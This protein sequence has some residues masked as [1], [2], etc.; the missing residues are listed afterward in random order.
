[1]E[2]V[3]FPLENIANV[4]DC[5]ENVFECISAFPNVFRWKR[6]NAILIKPG[7]PKEGHIWGS[8][9]TLL[10]SSQHDTN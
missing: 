1:M 4:S 7:F 3:L 8:F 5:I 10:R 2:R 9:T 6:L